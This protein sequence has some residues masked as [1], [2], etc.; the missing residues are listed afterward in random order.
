MAK[1]CPLRL[2]Q[3]QQPHRNSRLDMPM[4]CGK[5]HGKLMAIRALARYR[6]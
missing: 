3:T 6:V 5:T 4:R 2:Q 1:R